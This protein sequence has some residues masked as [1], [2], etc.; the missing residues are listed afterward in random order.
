MFGSGSGYLGYGIIENTSIA[1]A[2][3]GIGLMAKTG[4]APTSLPWNVP[5]MAFTAPIGS[6]ILPPAS[7]RVTLLS[8]QGVA[9]AVRFAAAG[10]VTGLGV[11]FLAR[12]API[13]LGAVGLTAANDYRVAML[14]G[15]AGGVGGMAIGHLVA[16]A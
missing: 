10:A 3:A 11:D 7:A 9:Q 16:N 5:F 13:T 4:R 6:G 14:S 8:G 12:G 2:S 1:A 15:A